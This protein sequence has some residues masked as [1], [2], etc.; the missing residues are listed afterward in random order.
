MTDSTPTIEVQRGKVYV[1]GVG[2]WRAP[3]DPFPAVYILSDILRYDK[4][5]QTLRVV[6]RRRGVTVPTM[7]KLMAACG[8]ARKRGGVSGAGK[9]ARRGNE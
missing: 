2:F 7:S 9:K 1:N 5:G 8:L 6:A 4:D 3:W